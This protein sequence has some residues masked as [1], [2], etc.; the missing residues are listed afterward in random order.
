M[1]DTVKTLREGLEQVIERL[2]PDALDGE[3]ALRLFENFV[4]P[5]PT[6]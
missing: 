2:D 4:A 1:F 6:T 5:H 3:R